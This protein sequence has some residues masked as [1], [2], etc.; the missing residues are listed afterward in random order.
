MIKFN[1]FNLNLDFENEIEIQDINNHEMKEWILTYNDIIKNGYGSILK[2]IVSRKPYFDILNFDYSILTK[3]Y[4]NIYGVDFLVNNLYRLDSLF[5][6]IEKKDSKDENK[7]FSALNNYSCFGIMQN[8]KEEIKRIASLPNAECFS[9][10]D[11]SP[12]IFNKRFI[13]YYGI[14]FLHKYIND[15]NPELLDMGLKIPQGTDF[16]NYSMELL[17]RISATDKRTLDFLGNIKE[18]NYDLLNQLDNDF[19]KT[20]KTLN[21]I[22]GDAIVSG[23]ITEINIVKKCHNFDDFFSKLPRNIYPLVGSIYLKTILKFYIDNMYYFESNKKIDIMDLSNEKINNLLFLSSNYKIIINDKYNLNINQ[24]VESSLI[25]N[26]EEKKTIDDI[27]KDIEISLF[28]PNVEKFYQRVNDAYSI[29][30]QKN[31]Q[32]KYSKKLEL[33]L[34]LHNLTNRNDLI[35]FVKLIGSNQSYLDEIEKVTK[36]EAIK[37]LCSSITKFETNSSIVNLNGRT[38]KL[39]V[40][41]TCG[42]ENKKTG[43]KLSADIKEWDK[44]IEEDSIISTSLINQYYLGMVSGKGSILGFNTVIPSDILDMGPTDIYSSKDIYQFNTRNQLSRFLLTDDLLYDSVDGYNEVVLK[45]YVNGKARY[46]DF[47]LCDGVVTDYSKEIAQ[48][49]NVPIYLLDRKAYFNLMQDHLYQLKKYDELKQYA[50]YLF[51]CFV[52]IYPE[53][54]I[55]SKYFKSDVLA[56]ELKEIIKEYTSLRNAE[57]SNLLNNMLD[58]VIDAYAKIEHFKYNQGIE[59]N[60]GFDINEMK[61]LVRK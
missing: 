7:L 36:V 25:K 16:N 4:I 57:N 33:I 61:A 22:F 52:S 35:L 39:L 59:V 3:D 20:V 23:F 11:Y 28:G 56:S 50:N 6:D 29:L 60:E 27:Y 46:P 26:I 24:I 32:T 58:D 45:R 48:Y 31:I 18:I 42:I 37:N 13:N 55:V 51:K 14:E 53:E 44:N 1:S 43:K 15:I 41:K 21:N 49:F 8:K 30:K 5:L 34:N 2:M 54:E 17:N 47:I 10:S 19:F 12:L 38:F 40:H 9:L